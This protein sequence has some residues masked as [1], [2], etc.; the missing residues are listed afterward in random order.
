MFNSLI[1]FLFTHTPLL[2]LTQSLWRDEAFSVLIAEPGGFESIKITAAD[3][4]PPLYYLLLNFWIKIFGKSEIS[5]RMLS[6]VFFLC[7][8][9]VFYKFAL[10]VFNKKLAIVLTTTAALCPILIYYGFEARMYS[11][12]ALTTTASMYFFYTKKWKPYIVVTTLALYTHPYTIFVPLTQGLYLLLKKKLT[13]LVLANILIPFIFYLPWI[14]VIINQ[15]KNSSQ[16]WIYPIDLNLIT[17]VLANLLVGFDG[18]PGFLW[19]YMKIF[20]LFLFI[21]YLFAFSKK[22]T[23]EKYLLF[24]LWVFVPLSIVLTVSYFKPIFVNRYIITVS[25]AQLFLLMVSLQSLSWKKLKIFSS[26][27]VLSI[28]VFFLFYLPPFIK[29]VNIR[30]TFTE[31]TSLSRKDDLVLAR[32]PLVFFESLYYFP[33]RERVYLYN[34]DMVKLPAYLGNVLIPNNKHTNT[35][36]T[37]PKRA[38]MVYENG[39]YELFSGFPK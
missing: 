3:F 39:S 38:F 32:S 31:I 17:S 19:Q 20:S 35:F 23:R 29:K 22:E 27:F 18:T 1:S 12:Y 37:Y 15:F 7:F 10:F 36:P 8:L 11:L 6:F 24:F 30:D 16:M 21:F 26:V 4:N 28:F 14:L 13:K 5:I 34:P 25:V 2:Y 9:Y 33:D